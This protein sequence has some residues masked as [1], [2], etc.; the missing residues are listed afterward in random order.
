[1]S[2][3]RRVLGA[4]PVRVLTQAA[5]AAAIMMLRPSPGGDTVGRPTHEFRLMLNCQPDRLQ[6]F[7]FPCASLHTLT[8][9]MINLAA[10]HNPRLSLA[11]PSSY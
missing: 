4:M 5:Q 8:R 2:L 11:L 6:G 9:R 10:E 1:M 7:K 3:T